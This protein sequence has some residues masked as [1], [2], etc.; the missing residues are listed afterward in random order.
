MHPSLAALTKGENIVYT[1]N[2]RSESLQVVAKSL[3]VIVFPAIEVKTYGP[4]PDGQAAKSPH[5]LGNP[6]HTLLIHVRVE[7]IAVVDDVYAHAQQNSHG[8]G[9]EGVRWRHPD[10]GF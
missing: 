1:N 6:N 2:L 7:R 8:I 9:I 5:L 10:L 4:N 3:Q